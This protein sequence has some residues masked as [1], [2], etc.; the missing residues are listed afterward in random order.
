ME[1]MSE[2]AGVTCCL[3]FSLLACFFFVFFS[4]RK[5]ILTGDTRLICLYVTLSCL[6]GLLPGS[7]IF[8]KSWLNLLSKSFKLPE[9][10]AECVQ[11]FL[12]SGQQTCT[13]NN[14][15]DRWETTTH[16]VCVRARVHVCARVSSHQTD[17]Q[18]GSCYSLCKKGCFLATE[19]QC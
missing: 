19:S 12:L 4:C 5:S 14:Y 1:I 7:I 17:T 13:R 9:Q 11:S 8:L 6:S 10:L 15:R 16:R 3:L 2:G 18:Q